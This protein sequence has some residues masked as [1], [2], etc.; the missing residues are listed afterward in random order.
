MCQASREIVW[1]LAASKEGEY[2]IKLT[3]AGE[4]LTKTLHVSSKLVRVSP[5]RLRGRFWERLFLVRRS[6]QYRTKVRSSPSLSTY[7]E[8]N[9]EIAGYEINWIWLFLYFFR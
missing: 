9:I 8:R 2:E 4:N 6:P 5:V 3:G 1:R 7:P